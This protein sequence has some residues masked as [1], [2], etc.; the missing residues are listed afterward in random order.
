M[1][2]IF[3][4]IE[5]MN[6]D[7]LV[8][9]ISMLE[10]LTISNS[11][12]GVAQ[13][14]VRNA[15][16][17][18]NFF[19][20]KIK[21]SD[22]I[23]EPK[24]ENMEERMKKSQEEINMLTRREKI[25][26]LNRILLSKIEYVGVPSEDEV[27][28]KI[29]N[30]AGKKYKVDDNF[31]PNQKADIIYTEC[32]REIIKHINSMSEKDKKELFK[33]LEVEIKNLSEKEQIA[34]KNKL[35]IKEI[36][37]RTLEGVL[38]STGTPLAI[39][40]LLSISGFGAS[41]ALTTIIHAIFTTILGITVPFG[42]YT[43]ATSTLAF[44]TGPLGIGL[45]LGVGAYS[46]L[47]NKGKIEQ[48]LLSTLVFF[49][50][51]SYGKKFTPNEEELPS[52]IPNEVELMENKKKE[53]F[54]NLLNASQ[55]KDNELEDKENELN[56]IRK[57]LNNISDKLK[58]ESSKRKLAENSLKDFKIYKL[59]LEEELE[60]SRLNFKQIEEKKF[61]EPNEESNEK[62]LKAKKEYLIFQ[63]K[64][65]ALKKNIDYQENIISKASEEIKEWEFRYEEKESLFQN[66]V[67]ENK[68]LKEENLKLKEICNKKIEKEKKYLAEKWALHYD[69]FIIEQEVLKFAIKL[70][71]KDLY[72]LE[73]A[74]MD[75]HSIKDKRALSRGKIND[76]G[77]KF[78]H[79]GFNLSTPCPG[80]IAYE[81]LNSSKKS[82]KI[83][84][85]YKHNSKYMN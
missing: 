18:V 26:R 76:G 50:I 79:M 39:I 17:V 53:E 25:I 12:S 80:R 58:K 60:K 1:P 63:E 40:G 51:A 37:S 71:R 46:L 70:N 82:V 81:V 3:N 43:T 69:N 19:S 84:K 54:I 5:R 4:G 78:D 13:K 83:V 7:L 74:L 11:I 10:T 28:V 41:I 14:T 30:L 15:A 73:K 57:A 47:K 24:V 42:V 22:L 35:Q 48:S 62:Y 27:S 64:T 72:L 32:S 56:N 33:D 8:L 85:V 67:K 34:I 20:N 49:S 29:I 52:W 38:K 23:K 9:Q 16:K 68:K 21:K 44:L 61:L 66:V 59:K 65:K 75:L 55:R 45:S 31:T 6:D 36:S 2:N 77:K